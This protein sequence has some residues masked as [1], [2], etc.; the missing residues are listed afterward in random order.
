MN[1]IIN[2]HP[3]AAPSAELICL[4]P[5]APIASWKWNDGSDPGNWTSN[6]WGFDIFDKSLNISVTGVAEWLDDSTTN[7]QNPDLK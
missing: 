4:V 5:G 1:N 2:R 6:K 7:P 3:Y